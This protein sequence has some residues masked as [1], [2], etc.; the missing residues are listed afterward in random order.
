MLEILSGI[1]R[2]ENFQT[3]NNT[4][5]VVSLY[6]KLAKFAYLDCLS[7]IWLT[8]TRRQL[9]HKKRHQNIEGLIWR[10]L[11]IRMIS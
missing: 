2:K 4:A 9:N 7:A 6:N 3:I 10:E 1:K 5:A 11:E 8:T